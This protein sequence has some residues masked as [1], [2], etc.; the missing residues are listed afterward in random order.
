PTRRLDPAAATAP[1]ACLVSEAVMH[2][3]AVAAPALGAFGV[4]RVQGPCAGDGFQLEHVCIDHRES[5]LCEHRAM[6]KS[7]P[8]D[9]ALR[10]SG[11]GAHM[12]NNRGQSVESLSTLPTK[13]MQILV[14][15]GSPDLIVHLKPRI[16]R[17][18]DASELWV[19]W[20]ASLRPRT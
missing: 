3:H 13:Q 5:L 19:I 18:T 4:F 14:L 12:P 10:A 20:P 15:V 8:A 6:R 1:R 9:I 16:V 7:Q 2:R 11:P 17:S